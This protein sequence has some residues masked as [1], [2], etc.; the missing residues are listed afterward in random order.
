MQIQMAMTM[1]QL[2]FVTELTHHQDM[3]QQLMV[4]IVTMQMLKYGVQAVSI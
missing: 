2:Q 3:L 4:Q 1:D